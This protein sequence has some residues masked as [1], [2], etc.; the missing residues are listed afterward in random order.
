M[1]VLEDCHWIDP[2]SRDLLELLARE[3]AALRVVVLLAYRPEVEPGGGLG[4]G[5]LSH[6]SEIR[7]AELEPGEAEELI[8]SRLEQLVGAGTEA[9]PALVELVTTRSQG[10]PFYVEELLNFIRAQDVDLQDDGALRRLQ[11]PESLH[12]LILSRIDTLSEAPRRTLKVA[13]VVGRTFAAPVLP[14]V[15]PELG[16][17]GEVRGHLGALGSLDLVK[18]DREDEEAYIFKH[19]VTQEV[20]YE[21]MPFAIRAVLHEHVGGYI[22]ETEPDAVDR[23]LDLLAH[24]YW[25]SENEPKKREYLVRAGDAAKASFANAVAVDYFERVVPLLEG[26]ERWAITRRLGEVLEVAGDLARAEA[27]Y[28]A[29]LA[30][31]EEMD[32]FAAA[33]WAES[34]LAE[35][36]RKRGDYDEASDWLDAAR[37]HF[38]SSGD[39][40]GIGRV[41]HIRGVVCNVRGNRTAAREHMEASLEIRREAGDKVAMG[42]LYSNLAIVAEYEGDYERSCA[43]HEE[44]L[45]LRIEAGDTAGIAVSQMNLGVMLQRLGRLDEAHAR[46]EESLRLRREI[47][48]PRMIALGEHNLGILT[49]TQGDYDTTK[50]L[51]AGALRVQRDQGDRWALAFMLEDVAVLAT[52]LD[53]PE[54][55]L[56]LAGAGAALREETRAPHGVAAAEELAGQL[57][58]AR[59]ALAERADEVWDEGRAVGLD[60]AVREALA[61]C[62][63]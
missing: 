32:D 31:A 3:S 7:L 9:P 38:E 44:G 35:L 10:N 30:L 1:L 51:F 15:Y 46:Q 50:D 29:A 55:A 24:H 39:R 58:P 18:L 6:F 40:L 56:R 53:E 60:E 36:T 41:E 23:N 16:S 4:I 11:L 8:R 45:A 43:L 37:G 52:L 20:A 61:F 48:D 12:S 25:L 19:V 57:A 13:S 22:E 17:L 33:G 54:L 26:A 21:S 62:G 28:R 14:V 49:R 42:A 63:E 47:G 5:R 34:S 59:E 2:L 27:S